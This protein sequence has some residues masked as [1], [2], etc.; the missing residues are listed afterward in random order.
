MRELRF[1]QANDEV[2]TILKHLEA[3]GA[4]LIG[5]EDHVRAVATTADVTLFLWDTTRPFVLLQDAE[6]ALR[7]LMRSACSSQDLEQ[8]IR[9]GAPSL[10]SDRP[11]RLEA[12]SLG[13]LLNVLLNEA[14]FGSVFR[15]VFGRNR[16]MVRSLLDPIREVRNKVFHFRDDVTA[17]ELQL[18]VSAVAWLRRKIIIRDGERS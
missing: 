17:E 3:D 11:V 15:T 8:A 10:D 6:L 14:N 12:L 13:Q 16:D 9:R 18:V 5:D 4:V 2:G 7:D 1:V